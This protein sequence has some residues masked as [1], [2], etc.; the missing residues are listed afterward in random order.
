M[1]I[2]CR[3]H[4]NRRRGVA[5]LSV[6]VATPAV[7]RA[8]GANAAGVAGM[9]RLFQGEDAAETAGADDS[10]IGGGP[11][12]DGAGPRHHVVHCTVAELAADV[13]A[14]TEQCV[15]DIDSARVGSTGVDLD[16]IRVT[17]SGNRIDTGRDQCPVADLS[18]P[19]VTPAVERAPAAQQRQRVLA[20]TTID[21]TRR[22]AR[23]PLSDVSHRTRMRHH[24]GNRRAEMYSS[25]SLRDRVCTAGRR[26]TPGRSRIVER[27]PRVTARDR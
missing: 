11:D 6:A 25:P 14:P 9:R 19:V 27:L 4:P 20:T 26:L 18:E 2:S 22:T 1:P 12:P 24:G 13:A 16:P 3:S 5:E 15:I 10:P 23:P 21:P 17:G 7:Q 8:T